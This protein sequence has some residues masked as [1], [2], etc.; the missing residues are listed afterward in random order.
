MEKQSKY[1]I[2]ND[3]E[4]YLLSTRDALKYLDIFFP[5]SNEQELFTKLPG[6]SFPIQFKIILILFFLFYVNDLD[7]RVM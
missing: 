4:C 2:R 5:E 3:G 7:A 1:E 6:F